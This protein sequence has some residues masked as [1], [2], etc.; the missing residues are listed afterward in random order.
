MTKDQ[1]VARVV[2]EFQSFREVASSVH[3]ALKQAILHYRLKTGDWEDPM[4]KGEMLNKYLS[5]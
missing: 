5:A 4:S 1:A 3:F 2:A